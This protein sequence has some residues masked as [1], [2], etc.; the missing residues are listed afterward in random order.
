MFNN[1]AA[2]ASSSSGPANQSQPSPLNISTSI[3][4]PVD[5]PPDAIARGENPFLRNLAAQNS[6][7][8]AQPAPFF[9]PQQ[10]AATTMINTVND[11]NASDAAIPLPQFSQLLIKDLPQVNV[12]GNE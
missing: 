10:S 3:I 12:I 9:V 5:S 8:Q 4:A 11:G 7:P 2:A 1:S 6:M